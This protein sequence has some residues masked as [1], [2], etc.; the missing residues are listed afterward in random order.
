MLKNLT[1]GPDNKCCVQLRDYGLLLLRLVA[2]GFMLTHG[3]PKLMNFETLSQTFP[4]TL[5]LGSK[6]ELILI[7]FAE[8]FASIALI[9]G[10]FTRLASIP[11]I[12]GLGVAAFIGH[13]GGPFKEM[14]L[15]LLYMSIYIVILLTGPGKIALDTLIYNKFCP[16]AKKNSLS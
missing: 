7:I 15:P 4:S 11:L 8:V 5:G 12:I 13:A 10:L 1:C 14:E 2:G 16:S 6:P 9:L 3:I